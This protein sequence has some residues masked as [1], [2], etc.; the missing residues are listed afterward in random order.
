M[1]LSVASLT[2]DFVNTPLISHR[3]FFFALL[4]CCVHF[5]PRNTDTLPICLRHSASPNGDQICRSLFF[6]L[7]LFLVLIC[8]SVVLY[9]C[10]C[11]CVW[12]AA[13]FPY[14]NTKLSS[15]LIFLSLAYLHSSL[16]RGKNSF[17]GEIWMESLNILSHFLERV[18]TVHLKMLN[19]NSEPCFLESH[20]L[21]S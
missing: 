18:E 1:Y 17:L 5:C 20:K 16:F 9:V 3:F 21:N 6:L 8:L 10:L 12:K 11:V 14:T 2:V 19:V 4:F 15:L 13:G 7:L